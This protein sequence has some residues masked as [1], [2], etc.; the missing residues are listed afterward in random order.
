MGEP[1]LSILLIH[2]NK[3]REIVGSFSE[4][5]L[6]YNVSLASEHSPISCQY[7]NLGCRQAWSGQLSR[8]VWSLINTILGI[9]LEEME[10][11]LAFNQAILSS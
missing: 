11:Q 2:E 9:Q 3:K 6:V 8:S 1:I 7:S 5:L 4:K 10:I